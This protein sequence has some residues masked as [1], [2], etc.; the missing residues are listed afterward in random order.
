MLLRFYLKSRHCQL[1]HE[2]WKKGNF[3]FGVILMN[4]VQLHHSI[5]VIN[6]L[7]HR[8]PSQYSL[9]LNNP[10]SM[11]GIRFLTVYL[12]TPRSAAIVSK[13][14]LSPVC[15][16]KIPHI[17]LMHILANAQAVKCISFFFHEPRVIYMCGSC[18]HRLSS[19]V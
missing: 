17:H 8:Y 13:F 14:R 19:F 9:I 6:Y 1:V 4:I 11:Q 18:T 10:H 5:T 2:H 3:C 12:Y 7:L 16:Q 15:Y